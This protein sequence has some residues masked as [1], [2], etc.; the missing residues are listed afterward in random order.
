LVDFKTGLETIL[1]ESDYTFHAEADDTD[2]FEVR[3]FN[4]NVTGIE[5]VQE[6][7]KV[8]AMN[9]CIV[10]TGTMD[11]KVAVYNAAGVLIATDDGENVT[12]DVAPGVYFVK[13]NSTTYKVFVEK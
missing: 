2:L 6:K 4:H 1:A 5:T 10:V 7:T 3:I 12:F 8:V 11:T 13:V 9:G